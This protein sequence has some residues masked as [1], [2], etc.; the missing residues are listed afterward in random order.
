[1]VSE[2]LLSRK[3]N[4]GLSATCKRIMFLFLWSKWK[5]GIGG[6]IF[7]YTKIRL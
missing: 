4:E 7:K 3:E 5:R 6:W 2:V 1:M